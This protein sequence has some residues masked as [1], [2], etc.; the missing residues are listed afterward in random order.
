MCNVPSSI[1]TAIV[2]V[3][4]FTIGRWSSWSIATHHKSDD[5]TSTKGFCDCLSLIFVGEIDDVVVVCL[6]L[7]LFTHGIFLLSSIAK[8]SK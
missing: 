2:V 1:L 8:A 3:V 5:E 6:S 7:T 4:I